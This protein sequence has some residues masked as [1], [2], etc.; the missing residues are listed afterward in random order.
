MSIASLD[1]DIAQARA[2]FTRL[3]RMHWWR[4]K[5]AMRVVYRVMP[6]HVERRIGQLADEIA[7]LYR[8]RS[9]LFAR[10]YA[11]DGGAEIA[12]R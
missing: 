8:F 5:H 11:L 2:E 9:E 1:H 12:D 6:A 3:N 4:R 10:N 7:G